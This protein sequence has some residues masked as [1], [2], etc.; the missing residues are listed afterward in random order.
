MFLG[1]PKCLWSCLWS[2]R[3]ELEREE[4]G[5]AGGVG[6]VA[7]SFG[8]H[9]NAISEGLEGAIVE[10]VGFEQAA[11]GVEDF[12][13]DAEVFADGF[14]SGSDVL[15]RAGVLVHDVDALGDEGVV[16]SV[17]LVGGD[18]L[19]TLHEH[20]EG[21]AL[22]DREAVGAGAVG[23][24][25]EVHIWTTNVSGHLGVELV[26]GLLIQ[27]AIVWPDARHSAAANACSTATT[28]AAHAALT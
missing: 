16:T 2:W 19:E 20:V 28:G 6:F 8:A 14:A 10:G 7:V 26:A 22:E 27:D 11:L 12:A 18:V 23:E 9:L 24:R 5:H 4:L 1:R 25:F 17:D 21:A 15:G 3:R 13:G